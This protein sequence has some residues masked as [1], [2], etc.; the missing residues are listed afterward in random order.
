M[1]TKL[2]CLLE[3]LLFAV[4]C[5]DDVPVQT[6]VLH[7]PQ[8]ADNSIAL[9]WEQP[10]IFGFKY[11]M[12][13]RAS[14][15]RNY[16]IINDTQNPAS[17]A[18]H[19]EIT[20]FTDNTY[21]IEADTLYYKVMAVGDKTASSGNV[22]FRNANK[23]TLLIGDFRQAYYIEGENKLS[24]VTDDQNGYGYKLKVFDLQSGQFLS[25]EAT[26][27]LSSSGCWSLWGKYNNKTEFYNYDS[28][29]TMYVYDAATAQQITSLTIPS[30][31]WY[32]PC[33]A[34]NKG[35]IYIYDY[36]VYCVNRATGTYT[37]Y[38]PT[39]QISYSNYLFYNSKDNKLYAI[40]EYYYRRII[41]FNLNEDGSIAREE[42]FTISDYNYIPI[43]IE[44]SSMFIININGQTNILDMNTKTYHTISLTVPSYYDY[45]NA[46]AI[47]AGDN[48][49]LSLSD[50]AN[51]YKI[52]TSDYKI[53]Q[54]IPLR[55]VPMQIFVFNGYLY[56]LGQYN[57]N[58][59][60][61]DKIKL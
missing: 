54:T 30:Y 47:F 21:P 50:G 12:V 53:F 60:L 20:S 22:L 42:V 29:W 24:V 7:T 58:A 10:D 40:D 52:S 14:D 27:N 3:V 55:V 57:D 43:Y 25:N 35:M 61:L 39:N 11:Y 9:N 49:Y 1:K 2:F 36:Y 5:K 44:N 18:F 19:K 28:D 45:N 38:Q 4:S 59:Y 8:Q 46:K 56:Y 6:L 26:I 34:N 16:E 51:I 41:T 37:Q 33:T 17:D 13:M 23:A 32:A 15:K 48:M 31:L